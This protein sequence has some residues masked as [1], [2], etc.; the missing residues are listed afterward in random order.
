M[1]DQAAAYVLDALEAEEA[2]EFERHVQVCP[3]CEHEL[4]PLRL[5]AA[6][7]AFAGELPQ[8]R[9]ALRRRVLAVDAVVLRFRRR[10]PAPLVSAAA[11]AACAALAV[12]LSRQGPASGLSL[13][14]DGRGLPPAPMGRVYEIWIVRDGHASPAGFLYGRRARLSHVPRGATVAVTLEPRGG[15]RKPTGPLLL[16]TETA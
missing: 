8:P 12:G 6:A 15:S 3:A 2:Q 14:V 11:L 1:H 13:P 10:R 9:S 4:E 7:L 5:A 16:K